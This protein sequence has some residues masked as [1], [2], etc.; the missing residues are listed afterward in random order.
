MMAIE[1]LTFRRYSKRG[2]QLGDTVLSVIESD[3]L[4]PVEGKLDW[5]QEMVEI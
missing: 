3:G 1:N 2:E 5:T 4:K